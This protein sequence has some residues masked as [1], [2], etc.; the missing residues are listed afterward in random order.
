VGA[1]AELVTSDGLK[2]ARDVNDNA[3]WSDADRSLRYQG[4]I[5]F[6]DSHQEW[7]LDSAHALGN[8][9]TLIEMRWPD[10]TQK[11]PAYAVRWLTGD[12]HEV[13]DSR[14]LPVPALSLAAYRAAHGRDERARTEQE[15]ENAAVRTMQRTGRCPTCGADA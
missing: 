14:P 15:I 12:V 11:L 2:L 9:W 8:G 10:R 7:D 13:K 1:G 3:G 6:L 5:A 4:L